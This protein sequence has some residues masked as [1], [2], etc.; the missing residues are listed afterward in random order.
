MIIWYFFSQHHDSLENLLLSELK[1]QFWNER[2]RMKEKFSFLWIFA[3]IRSNNN[4]QFKATVDAGFVRY[5]GHKNL[6]Q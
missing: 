2:E 3:S 1:I 5:L 4:I 6:K